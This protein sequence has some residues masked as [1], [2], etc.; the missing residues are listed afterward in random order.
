MRQ[1]Y[2]E[3]PRTSRTLADVFVDA[4]ML[5]RQ[6]A[7]EYGFTALLGA[8]AGA[9][10][11]VFLR[12]I[13]GPLAIA[14]MAPAAFLAAL[15]TY[16]TACAAIRRV[17]ENLEPDTFRA[18]ASACQRAQVIVT[19]MFLPLGLTFVAVLAAS[20]L[21]RWLGEGVATMLALLLILVAAIPAFQRALFIPALFARTNDA[22]E[23]A[24][25]AS[26]AMRS[27][28]PA[29]AVLLGAALVPAGLFGL[30]ALGAGFGTVT[31]AIAAI[32]FILT[33]P[34]CAAISTLIYD[35]VAPKIEAASTKGRRRA[36]AGPAAASPV[37]DRLSRIRR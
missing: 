36:P 16:A 34:L 7:G 33:M 18:F 21:D 22:I 12:A 31:A 4:L 9:V 27:A 20:I 3:E 29:L 37:E 10:L 25:R 14:L 30:I 13:G 2:R 5:V 6:D 35:T 32:A 8:G 15:M 23:A 17:E 11:V 19:P 1:I 28:G 26:Q 24:E